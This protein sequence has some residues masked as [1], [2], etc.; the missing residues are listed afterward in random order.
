MKK[1]FYYLFTFALLLQVTVSIVCCDDPFQ[2]NDEPGRIDTIPTPKPNP[3]DTI[4]KPEPK[5]LPVY[6]GKESFEN[7]ALE[8]MDEFKASDFENILEL[9]EYIINEYAEYEYDEAEEWFNET[10]Q[11]L[12]KEETPNYYKAVYTLS[13]FTGKLVAENGRWKRYNAKNLSINVNDQNGNPCVV[14]LTTSGTKKKVLI[15]EEEWEEDDVRYEAW[16]ELPQTIKVVLEQNG[17]KLA[18]VIINTDLSSISGSKLN[19]NKDKYNVSTTI[20]FNGYSFNIEKLTY[21]NK[22]ESKAVFSFKHDSRTL[23]SATLSVTPGVI[24]EGDIFE[25]IEVEEVTLKNN[26]LSINVLDSLEIKGSCTD[27]MKVIEILD[28]DWD[29]YTDS[30]LNRYFDINLYFYGAKEATA[31]VEFESFN[32]RYCTDCQEYHYDLVPVMVFN[33][34][35]RHSCEEFFNEE[36]FQTTIKAFSALLQ[37]FEDLIHGFEFDY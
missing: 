23:L 36:D 31:S 33:D 12:Y 19:I 25:D 5:P 35:S 16:V 4:L 13:A 15:Y 24:A 32:D 2:N 17:N 6:K 30:K 10:V 20:Y 8:F 9:T 28:D 18:E 14:T 11:S 21:E 3:D 7:I 27:L 26:S 29:E 37:E 22:K 34:G 1:I